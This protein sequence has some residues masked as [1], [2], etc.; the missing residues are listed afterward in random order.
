MKTDRSG[1]L[2]LRQWAQNMNH[3]IQPALQAGKFLA[4]ACGSAVNY[5]ATALHGVDVELVTKDEYNMQLAN[6]LGLFNKFAQ[7]RGDSQW[8][9]A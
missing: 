6:K 8:Q 2:W 4:S 9:L 7:N 1:A 5:V 3:E